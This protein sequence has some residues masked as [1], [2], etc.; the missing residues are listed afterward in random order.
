MK[1][2][3]VDGMKKFFSTSLI[4]FVLFMAALPEAEAQRFSRR[5]LYNSVGVSLNA[6][7]YFGDVTPESDFT[8]LRLSSTRPSISV[9]FTRKFTPR[10]YGRAALS[11]GRITGDD[12]KSAD[13]SEPENEPRY[14]R[15]LSF[16]ND[17]KELSV[18]GIVDLFENRRTFMRRPDF[19]P[20]AFA[21]V[22]VFH[23]NPKAYYDG[24]DSR[25]AAGWYELQ[26]LGTEG[27]YANGEGYPDPYKK[28]QFAIPFG[29][30]VRYKLARY[31]DLGF[32]ITWRK[33]FT[34]YLDDVSTVYAD[35]SQ[36]STAAAI[37]SDRSADNSRASQYPI[38]T[39]NGYRRI[40]GYGAKGD[41][42]GDVSD[43]DWYITTGFSLNYILTPTRRGPKFR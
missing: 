15:N 40:A 32:E 24:T 38:I 41:Q 43:D 35:K 20:Y 36:L 4:L 6:M 23:H 3:T 30:G 33:T 27:Q 13:F 31:W 8:S 16:R 18:Q 5:N 22:A 21:G 7:N 25:L 11:W 19:T 28:I 29:L 26:P 9:N 39:E 12:S 37:L 2:V 17:I 42:R 10:I 14:K 1:S 34:D